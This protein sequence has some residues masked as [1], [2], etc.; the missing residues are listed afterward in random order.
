MLPFGGPLT[1]GGWPASRPLPT[2]KTDFRRLTFV[3]GGINTTSKVGLDQLGPAQQGGSLVKP[4]V[5][6]AASARSG[7]YA[8]IPVS[9]RSAPPSLHKVPHKAHQ[10]LSLVSEGYR[11]PPREEPPAF[12]QVERL[13]AEAD[14]ARVRANRVR[15]GVPISL[16]LQLD[17]TQACWCTPLRSNAAAGERFALAPL[18]H[19]WY[20]V[21]LRWTDGAWGVTAIRRA[22]RLEVTVA[23]RLLDVTA[24]LPSPDKDGAINLA[25]KGDMLLLPLS[26]EELGALRSNAAAT[27]R[28]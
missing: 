14:Q 2:S 21:A 3:R 22:N 11:Q 12:I 25:A 6:P 9:L 27:A 1:R 24:Y 15:H 19:V 4:M 5:S 18:N 7:A 28:R 8:A 17:W 10:A 13:R 26:A 20:G 16:S 23:A